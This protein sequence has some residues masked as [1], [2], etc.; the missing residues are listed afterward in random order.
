MRHGTRHS[1]CRDGQDQADARQRGDG[2]THSASDGER[3]GKN[4]AGHAFGRLTRHQLVDVKYMAQANG[5]ALAMWFRGRIGSEPDAEG[6]CNVLYDDGDFEALVPSCFLRSP[7]GRGQALSRCRKARL[8]CWGRSPRGTVAVQ[9]AIGAWLACRLPHRRAASGSA[10]RA[11]TPRLLR[12]RGCHGQSAAR[13]TSNRQPARRGRSSSS[14]SKSEQR[15]VQAPLPH[16]GLRRRHSLTF[17][18]A[19]SAA[20]IQGRTSRGGCRCWPAGGIGWRIQA[21]GVGGA[22]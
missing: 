10:H 11:G 16:K 6:R 22:R 8:A 20:Y 17:N 7:R 19:S 5:H 12:A 13:S 1:R 9:P 14:S 21:I 4:S 2:R 18:E 15:S 3:D